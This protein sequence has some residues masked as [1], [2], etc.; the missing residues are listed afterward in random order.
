[1][2]RLSLVVII[3]LR[4]FLLIMKIESALLFQTII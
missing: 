1:M 3:V 4:L 2:R